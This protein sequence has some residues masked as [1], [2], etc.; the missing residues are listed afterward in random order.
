MR[1]YYLVPSQSWSHFLIFVFPSH[2]FHKGSFLCPHSSYVPVCKIYITKT[3]HLE[4][5]PDF[6]KTKRRDSIFMKQNGLK[7]PSPIF[8]IFFKLLEILVSQESSYF[9]H[10][11]SKFHSWKEFH[12]K[13]INEN[14][15]G[16]GNHN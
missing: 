16:Y 8:S 2:I 15:S 11:H 9:S 14:V 13:D 4:V 7:E 12:L 6:E 1:Y 3:V 5:D 10:N